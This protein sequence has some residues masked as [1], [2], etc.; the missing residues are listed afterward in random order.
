[1]GS[2]YDGTWERGGCWEGEGREGVCFGARMRTKED[3]DGLNEEPEEEDAE[4]AAVDRVAIRKMSPCE[5]N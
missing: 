5:K 4:F 3:S 1:M 2:E